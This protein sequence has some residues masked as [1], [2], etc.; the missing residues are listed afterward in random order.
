LYRVEYERTAAKELARL[1]RQAAARVVEA[2]ELLAEN[3]RPPGFSKIVGTANG[4]RIRVGDY[5][6]LYAIEDAVLVIVV[7][8]IA[9]REVVYRRR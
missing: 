5:R 3:P 4:Y 1:P 7:V 2:I 9:K 8:R 6:V